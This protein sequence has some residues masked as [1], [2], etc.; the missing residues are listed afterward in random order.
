MNAVYVNYTCDKNWNCQ[1]FEMSGTILGLYTILDKWGYE[2]DTILLLSNP[3][4]VDPAEFFGM[5][6]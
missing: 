6:W 2:M 4:G 1:S 5:S 3:A